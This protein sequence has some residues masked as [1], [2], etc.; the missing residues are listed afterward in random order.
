MV[1]VQEGRN[2]PNEQTLLSV[3]K[4]ITPLYTKSRHKLF[5][6]KLQIRAGLQECPTSFRLSHEARAAIRSS[7]R[8]WL[9]PTAFMHTKW[10]TEHQS[11]N[12]PLLTHPTALTYY[13]T[14][15]KYPAL[16]AGTVSVRLHTTAS[17]TIIQCVQ[18]INWRYIP[19]MEPCA[20]INRKMCQPW[21]ITRKLEQNQAAFPPANLSTL[22]TICD[23]GMWS[24]L[25]HSWVSFEPLQTA[26]SLHLLPASTFRNFEFFVTRYIY[27]LLTILRLYRDFTNNISNRYTHLR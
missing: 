10:S 13:L 18:K 2:Y 15:P 16:T 26:R 1:Y 6:Q 11:K 23:Q 24:A 3:R 4:A 17:L 20:S 19:R 9:T 21:C 22:P 27:I 8:S 5:V 14:Y 7:Q 25:H 12:C